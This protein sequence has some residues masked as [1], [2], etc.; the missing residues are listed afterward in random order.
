V[1]VFVFVVINISPK[2]YIRAQA[3]PRFVSDSTRE[4]ERREQGGGEWKGGNTEM[5]DMQEDSQERMEEACN[6][7][8]KGRGDGRWFVLAL[9]YRCIG[10]I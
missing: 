2:R 1:F 6:K 10:S 4:R 7:E 9:D 3:N 8:Q 5:Y